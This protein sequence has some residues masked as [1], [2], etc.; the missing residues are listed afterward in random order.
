M[1]Y[2]NK[3]EYVLWVVLAERYE[4]IPGARRKIWNMMGLHSHP[5]A[6]THPATHL[7]P[8]SVSVLRSAAEFAKY[9][10]LFTYIIQNL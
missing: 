6:G 2:G 7:S 10:V 3:W 9:N 5:T 1:C 8:Y 4:A